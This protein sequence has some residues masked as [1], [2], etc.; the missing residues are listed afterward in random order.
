M[1]ARDPSTL[2]L[3]EAG[4]ETRQ[5]MA[6]MGAKCSPDFL[7]RAMCL[8]NDAD[9]N[10]RNAS[11]KQFLIELTLAKICQLLSP[12]PIKAATERGS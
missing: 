5:A 9:L 2:A 7:Y 1:V 10:Y 3:I 6:A 11:N 4:N 8:C 12:S